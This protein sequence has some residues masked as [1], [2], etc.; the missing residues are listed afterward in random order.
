MSAT[1]T[2]KY[3]EP[4]VGSSYRQLFIKG[5]KLRADI[6]YSAAYQR[7]GE[8]DRTPE[9]VAE[10]YGIPVEAVYEAIRYCESKPVEVAYDHRRTDLLI[11]AAGMNHPEHVNDPRAH[12]RE[13]TLED[14]NRI[15]C[16]LEDEF[17]KI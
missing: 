11:E 7:G 9:Q 13:L 15:D 12:R 3:L 4:H 17:G 8:D 1:T 16:Q 10:D 6:I 14:L 5:T 2:Y